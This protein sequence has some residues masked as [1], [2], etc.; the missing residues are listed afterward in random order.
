M[1]WIALLARLLLAGVFMVAAL[2]KL[3]DRKG[4]RAALAE[5]GV[6][7]WFVE[8]LVLLLPLAELTIAG[9]VLPGATARLGALAALLLLGIFT[10]GIAITLARGKQPDCHCFG[11]L[12]SSPIGRSTVVRNGVLGVV[13]AMVVWWGGGTPDFTS[14]SPGSAMTWVALGVAIV[15]LALAVVE[16]LFLLSLLPQQGRILIRLEKVESDLGRGPGSGVPIGEQ[17]PEF[18]L[19]S[20]SDERLTLTALRS[21]GKPVLLFFSNPHCAPCDA[22]LPEVARWQ[23]HHAN[24]VT[25]AVITDGPMDVNRVKA[26]KHGLRTVMLQKDR[27]VKE[28][29]DI[30]GTPSAVLV[31]PD[32]SIAG[33]NAYGEDRVQDLLQQALSRQASDSSMVVREG[34]NGQRPAP[35]QRTMAI[36]Q[37]T[38]PMLLPDLEGKTIDLAGSRGTSTLVLFWSPSCGFCQQ[39]LPELKKWERRRQAESP[40]LLVISTGSVEENRAMGFTSPVVLD[41]DGSSMHSFG[42]SGTPT[43]VL[44]DAKG[45][46]ASSLAVGAEAVMALA[47]NRVNG[48]GGKHPQV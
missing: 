18:E 2:G 22:L 47:R 42:A 25:V 41:T 48:Q 15:A 17:A 40:E 4:L 39:M 27:E 43:A 5:F 29:Y 6:P 32:G 1:E 30:A 35:G 33:R 8:P 23:H 37:L 13:A 45:R 34:M 44:V 14:M 19:S 10:A 26:D 20:L 38:P 11:Q 7:D 24:T 36:G 9:L 28:A 31:A 16:G 46:I 3:A 21:A 12:H